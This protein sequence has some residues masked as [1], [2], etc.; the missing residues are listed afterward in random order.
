MVDNL[1]L[2]LIGLLLIGLLLCIAPELA[3]LVLLL[4]L[5]LLGD[6]VLAGLKLED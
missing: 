1:Q 5:S 4:L 3:G 6:L 2:F